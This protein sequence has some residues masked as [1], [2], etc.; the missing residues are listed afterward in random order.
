MATTIRDI[1]RAANVSIGTVSRALKNQPGL[2]ESTRQRVVETAQ[3]LGYDAA[4]LRPRIRRLTFLLHRQHNNFGASPFF[5]HV[6][7]G[8]EDACRVHGIVP[9]LLTAGPTEDIAEQLRLHAPDAIAVAGFVEPETLAAVAAMQRP[10][11]L[12]D[13]WA[14]NMRSVNLDNAEGA[15]IAM[16]H[17]FSLGRKRVAFIGG[18]LAHYS[19]AQR[20]QGD[21]R[22]LF[23]AGLLF[24]PSLE[25]TIDAHLPPE[26]GAALAMQRLLDTHSPE[27]APN[28][29]F[30]YNDVAAL[31]AMRVALARGLRVPED[32]AFVGFDD[33]PAASHATPSLTTIAID[34]EALG[35]RGVQMLLDDAPSELTVRLPVQLVV[36][37]STAGEA[38]AQHALGSAGIESEI[39][40]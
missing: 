20:A 16:R 24:D 19:I 12:I 15:A 7:H 13:L 17:L 11:V 37:A 34:K 32:I 23:E 28:A 35:A 39:T 33:I 5:S 21:R 3:R 36:R 22:A 6:L 40:S 1:A 31:A 2:S 30:A 25:T 29:V 10:L 26:E 8:V 9:S 38:R 14:P 18:S 4:Q 27:H